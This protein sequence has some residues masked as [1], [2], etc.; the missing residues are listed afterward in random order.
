ML[1]SLLLLDGTLPDGSRVD[2]R[3]AEGRIRG[4]APA[5][6]RTVGRPLAVESVGF[7]EAVRSGAVARET[8]I[9]LGGRLVLPAL[10]NGHAHLDK[11]FVGSPWQ[12]HRPGATVAERVSAERAIR[13]DLDVPVGERAH[14]LAAAMIGF[15]TGTVRTHVDIDPAVGLTS[16][17]ALLDLRERLRDTLRVQVVAFPQ[18]GIV[19]SPGVSALLEEALR[20][21]ADAIGGLDPVGFDQDAERH[22]DTVFGLAARYDVGVDIHLHDLGE[23]ARFQY[24]MIAERT[25]RHALAGRVVVSHAYGLGSLGADDVRRVGAEF[26]ASGVAV[27]T[28]GPAGPM[29]PVLAM[30]AEGATVFSGSDNI[31]DAWWPYGDGDMLAVARQVA[32]QSNFRTDEELQVALDL[33]TDS[34]ACA[35][36]I[37]DYGVHEGAPADLLIIDSPSPAAAVAAHPATRLVLHGGRIV[38]AQLA[39]AHVLAPSTLDAMATRP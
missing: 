30:R 37:Q 22:L 33:V 36:G 17:D 1:E 19:A 14:A 34:A 26:A 7:E 25:R 11:T 9:D 16:L 20:A 23:P 18:S 24:E 10:I 39:S 15:G 5:A 13:D 32:Y 2:L 27:M 8:T 21:G 4:I 12:P 6:G 35:L 31:R 28:N 38:A 3:I 29:P